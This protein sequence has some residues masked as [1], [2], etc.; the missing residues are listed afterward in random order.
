MLIYMVQQGDSLGKIAARYGI[1]AYQIIEQ[2]QLK[3]P[4]LLYVGQRLQ[5]PSR[6][7]AAV[8]P[9]H[10]PPRPQPAEAPPP[11]PQPLTSTPLAPTLSSK[12]DCCK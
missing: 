1:T 8:P 5:I 12:K 7:P 9:Q 6:R 10:Q 2:N 11:A 4:D 3:N